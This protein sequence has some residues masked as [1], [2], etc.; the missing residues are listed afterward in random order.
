MR[1]PPS[2]TKSPLWSLSQDTPLSPL[3]LPSASHFFVTP[4]FK[5][6]AKAHARLLAP[7]GVS[8]LPW[9]TV[10][11]GWFASGCGTPSG[12]ASAGPR[13][14]WHRAG[15]GRG[16]A[17]FPGLEGP[18]VLRFRHVPAARCEASRC[19]GR[20]ET[21]GGPRGSCSLESNAASLCGGREVSHIP[22]D[23]TRVP[24]RAA[25]CPQRCLRTG[26]G[27]LSLVVSP[28]HLLPR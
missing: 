21:L 20:G 11:G 7:R 6:R 10:L 16:R 14:P 3:T 24:M 22:T 17:R 12:G 4:V 8:R 25:R 18:D 13:R 15:P 26:V 28:L 5:T 1:L 2:T 23:V 27:H 19:S 9:A